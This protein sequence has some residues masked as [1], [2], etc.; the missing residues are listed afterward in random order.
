M[1]RMS[2][3][4]VV[5]LG[6]VAEALAAVHTINDSLN[7]PFHFATAPNLTR[8]DYLFPELP[9]EPANLLPEAPGTVEA[10]KRLGLTMSEPVAGAAPD[11]DIPAAYTYFGQFIDHDITLMALPK[12][13]SLQGDLTPLSPGEASSIKNVRTATLDLDSVYGDAPHDGDDL[14]LVAR[15]LPSQY[16]VMHIPGKDEF[17]D[18]P[19]EDKSDDPKHHLAARVGDA[20][21]DENLITSQLHVAFLRAHNALVKKGHTFCE[22]RKLLR[23]HYQWVVLDD[24]LKR[25]ADPLVVEGILSNPRGIYDPPEDGFFLPLEFTGAAFRFGHS[26]VRHTY[27]YNMFSLNIGLLSLINLPGSGFLSD[28]Q[29]W[30]NWIIQWERFVGDGANMARPIDTQLVR[31]LVAAAKLGVKNL[32]RGYQLRLPTGQA[33]ARALRL[34]GELQEDEI[35]SEADILAVAAG[36]PGSTQAD[37][38]R[39]DRPLGDGTTWRLS[40]RTPLWFY[41]LAEAAHFKQGRCLGPVGSRLVASVLIGLIRRSKD[42]IL[43]TPGWIPTLQDEGT[44]FKLPDLLHL[45]GVLQNPAL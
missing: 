17:N 31:P 35:M 40:A 45:A 15:V 7:V 13:G 19:R 6:E 33:V 25:V 34:R 16:D 14:L 11:S 22:A 41:L 44:T 8:L 4:D 37:E 3:G 32:Q 1:P 43:N 5:L 29:I 12:G 28:R 21:N 42:S 24:Y 36:I 9:S 26:M 10:L 20:R 2:H 38:L 27:N 30:E 39:A 18:L 23:Q